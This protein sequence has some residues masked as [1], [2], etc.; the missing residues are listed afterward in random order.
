MAVAII[1]ARDNNKDMIGQKQPT[2]ESIVRLANHNQQE[3][4]FTGFSYSKVHPRGIWR[5]SESILGMRQQRSLVVDKE[6]VILNEHVRG[7]DDLE[8]SKVSFH[9]L[10]ESEYSYFFYSRITFPRP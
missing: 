10:C 6:V 3:T 9:P 7:W 5:E 1:I 4:N 8:K 2:K